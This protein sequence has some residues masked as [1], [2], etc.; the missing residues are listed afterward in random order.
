MWEDSSGIPSPVGAHSEGALEF[1]A[2]SRVVI[3]RAYCH[4]RKRPHHA[5]NVTGPHSKTSL[6]GH[7]DGQ[8][9]D[10]GKGRSDT[11]INSYGTVRLPSVLIR[12]NRKADVS[13]KCLDTW[14]QHGD[15]FPLAAATA[16]GRCTGTSRPRD[17]PLLR[18]S[19]S[20]RAT[21]GRMSRVPPQTETELRV[22]KQR[23]RLNQTHSLEESL[24]ARAQQ[25]AQPTFSTRL[26]YRERLAAKTRGAADAG[27]I[28]TGWHSVD[29]AWSPSQVG[30]LL[31]SK[32]GLWSWLD[33]SLQK[34]KLPLRAALLIQIRSLTKRPQ[35][36]GNAEAVSK[37]CPS[38]APD[39]LSTK[40]V[41]NGSS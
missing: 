31:H 6:S 39:C 28:I 30:S 22:A 32:P 20:T 12:E 21:H 9:L 13:W 19:F 15:E 36:R 3:S 29:L 2:N 8:G 37:C 17:V 25:A 38:E 1:A 40:R 16:A 10:E 23:D 26:G 4:E 14:L 24:V 33:R 11:L 18:P 5:E 35:R 27:V 41:C 7:L 34:R